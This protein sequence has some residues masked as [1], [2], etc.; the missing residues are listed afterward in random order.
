[1]SGRAQIGVVAL[2]VVA[3]AIASVVVI[4]AADDGWGHHSGYGLVGG[5]ALPS[6]PGTV[7]DVTLVNMGGSMM[8]RGASMNGGM[9]RL[10]MNRSSVAAGTVS[11]LATNAG[12]IVHELVIL[13]L[14][15]PQTV[16]SRTIGDDAR[17]D[18]GGSLGEASATCGA[19]GGDGIAPGSSG[20]VT[21]DLPAGTYEI[22]CNLPGHYGAGMYSQLVVR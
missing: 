2:A 13:P 11:F 21:V 15:A 10:T 5:C 8:G 4:A 17:I 7:V 18:E 9:M 12:N 22:V 6:L 3:L 20:W 1:V 16:G 19:G 14:V